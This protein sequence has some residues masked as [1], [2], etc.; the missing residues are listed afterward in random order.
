LA[1][2]LGYGLALAAPEPGWYYAVFV[3]LGVVHAAVV[4]P[5]ILVVMEFCE[6]ERRPTYIGLAN[7]ATGVVSIV[8]PLLGALLAS[9]SY[10][11]LFAITA[12]LNLAAVTAMHWG[13][14]EP[15]WAAARPT[16]D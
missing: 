10:G 6:P 9:I 14:R 16:A 4:V 3:L 15:R 2:V 5:G 12:C 7:T 1:A 8:A 11:W 13:V